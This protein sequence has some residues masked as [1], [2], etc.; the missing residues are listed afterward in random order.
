[1]PLSDQFTS[2]ANILS[3]LPQ[4]KIAQTVSVL[5]IVYLAYLSAQITWLFLV[6]PDKNMGIAANNSKVNN[7]QNPIQNINL[8]KI[9]SL[10]L[11]G[12]YQAV[13]MPDEVIEV[14]DAPETRLNLTLTG[15]VASSE[16]NAGAAIIENAGQQETYGIGEKI[17]GTRATLAQVMRDR[18]LIKQAGRLE[19]LMLDGFEYKKVASSQSQKSSALTKVEPQNIHNQNT[20]RQ[21]IDLRKNKALARRMAQL[22]QDLAKNPAKLTD[23]LKIS[24]ARRDGRITGYK[25]LPGKDTDFFKSA[26]LRAGDIAI[27]MNGYDLT[28]PAQAAQALKALREDTEI[29]LTV[30]RQGSTSEI[31]F[32]INK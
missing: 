31:L 20:K 23:Y 13:S 4:K 12:R 1:M 5:L 28:E 26:G 10:N 22:K 6:T 17:K 27:A 7:Q 19:T 21:R 2:L 29:S 25:L 30:D 8:N 14:K 15:V 24:P 9:N 18:V 32:S 11:F 16:K 3:R